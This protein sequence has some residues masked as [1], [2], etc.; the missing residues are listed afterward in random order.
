M[1]IKVAAK[2]LQSCPTLCDPIDGSPPGS[3]IPGIFQ[4]R[5]LE[6]VA[7]S[8]SNAGKWKVKVK[9]ISRTHL[10]ATPWTAA[11]QAPPSMG[12]SRQEYWSG[13]PLHSLT[14]FLGICISKE[15]KEWLH[16]PSNPHHSQPFNLTKNSRRTDLNN[17]CHGGS[18]ARPLVKQ[19]WASFLLQQRRGCFVLESPKFYLRVGEWH[20]AKAVIGGN[21]QPK[22][23]TPY[24]C[25]VI[26]ILVL[27]CIQAECGEDNG[28][29][30]HLP[31]K[32]HGRRG[33]VGCSPWGH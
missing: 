10:C 7:I 27:G 16:I 33:L 29:P 22:R 2:S 30:L 31:G 24:F 12:F 14:N 17:S 25:G 9:S 28:T 18:P 32:S 8:F 6:W 1:H 26:A 20:R 4:A 21:S 13:V 23:W 5:T 19:L 15:R 11:Y 3:P